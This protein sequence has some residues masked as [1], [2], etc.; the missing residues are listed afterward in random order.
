MM[1]L[2]CAAFHAMAGGWAGWEG[3][4][5]RPLRGD[6]DGVVGVEGAVAAPR[7]RDDADVVVVDELVGKR[8]LEAAQGVQDEEHRA[9]TRADETRARSH[10]GVESARLLARAADDAG[11]VRAVADVQVRVGH[12]LDDL[13]RGEAVKVRRLDYPFVRALLNQT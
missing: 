5:A 4:V 7:V 9:R 2:S 11:A 8:P 12:V 3:A 1:L 6:G 13:Q 10:P